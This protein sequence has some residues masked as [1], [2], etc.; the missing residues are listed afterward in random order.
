MEPITLDRSTLERYAACPWQAYVLGLLDTLAA[1][2]RGERIF[3][4]ERKRLDEADPK[5][6]EE[7]RKY[8]QC[9]MSSLICDSGVEVHRIID[10]AFSESKGDLEKIPEWIEENLP[11]SRPDIQPQ[12][13]IAARH[14][15][16]VLADLHISVIG[17]E[18]QMEYVLFPETSSRAAVIITQAM[19]LIGEGREKALHIHDWKSGHKRRTN[20]E[21]FESFQAQ[22]AALIVWKQKAYAEVQKIYWWYQET[23]FGTKAFAKFER[24]E[25]HPRLPH[26]TQEI[27]FECRMEEAAK[28]FLADVRECWPMD[29]KCCWCDAIRWCTLAHVDAQ[30]IAF[31]ERAF[32]DKLIVDE[33]S[34][35]RR[36]KAATEWLKSKGPI[37]GT[38]AV[39]QQKKPQARFTGEVAEKQEKRDYT[40][41]VALSEPVSTGDAAIDAFF[42]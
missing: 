18:I 6:I 39:F 8:A 22:C 21:A 26:L 13:I 32:I 9:G 35:R 17:T 10:Q 25:F 42:K 28:L 15:C 2:A 27:A 11:R 5:L 3:A 40:K 38:V 12:V 23:R 29:A 20:A 31:D 16:D 24:G 14:V 36:K 30:E 4:W 37:V 41:T 33:E 34:V 7:L 1:L 19:D